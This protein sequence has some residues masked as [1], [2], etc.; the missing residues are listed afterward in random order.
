MQGCYIFWESGGNLF[1]LLGVPN[2]MRSDDLKPLL[3]IQGAEK[4]MGHVVF[5]QPFSCG[6]LHEGA[7]ALANLAELREHFLLPTN[8]RRIEGNRGFARDEA[9]LDYGQGDVKPL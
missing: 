4:G 7:S 9:R 1:H 3:E 8:E 6:L 2:L 5:F